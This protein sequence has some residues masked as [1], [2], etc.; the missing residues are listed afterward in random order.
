MN[1]EEPKWIA[2]SKTV[3]AIIAMVITVWLGAD[4]SAEATAWFE[5]LVELAPQVVT[6]VLGII[7]F[8]GRLVARQQ[9]T[10]TPR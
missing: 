9:V 10:L 5:V 1:K 6:T 7:G 8:V 3:W 4:I 2:K